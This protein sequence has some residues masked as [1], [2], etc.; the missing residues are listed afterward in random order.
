MS[1]SLS[2]VLSETFL[3]LKMKRV[4]NFLVQEFLLI[5]FKVVMIFFSLGIVLNI[6]E[7]IE[8]FKGMDVNIFMPLILSCFYVPNTIIQILP[9]VVFIKLGEI[10]E[11]PADNRKQAQIESPYFHWTSHTL[12]E[13]CKYPLDSVFTI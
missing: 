9:F 6:F 11:K 8:F 3:Q 5:F 4:I 7:E 1:R 13:Y 12:A 2:P 10:D